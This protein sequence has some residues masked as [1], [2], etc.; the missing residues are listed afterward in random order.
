MPIQH[1][2][3]DYCHRWPSASTS[4]C[5]FTPIL[6]SHISRHQGPGQFPCAPARHQ[7]SP[8]PGP[9][10]LYTHAL[11]L[12]TQVNRCYSELYTLAGQKYKGDAVHVYLQE[13][14]SYEKGYGPTQPS[15]Y[16]DPANVELATFEVGLGGR[17]GVDSGCRGPGHSERGW[18]HPGPRAIA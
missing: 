18:R 8:S 14:V 15:K 2:E 17:E 6:H 4:P 16:N 3:W 13:G 1:I 5:H 7:R 10:A 12:L 11:P 9:A